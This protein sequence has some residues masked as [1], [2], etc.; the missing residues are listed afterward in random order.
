MPG[1][2][3]KLHK[4]LYIGLHTHTRRRTICAVAL[5]SLSVAMCIAASAPA[6][7]AR[8][9]I[10][11]ETLSSLPPTPPNIGDRPY[12]ERA[13]ATQEAVDTVLPTILAWAGR[14]AR[15]GYRTEGPALTPGGYQLKTSP[16]VQLVLRAGAAD[17]TRLGAAVGFV[18]RQWAVMVSNAD[19]ETALGN[20]RRHVGLVRLER[21]DRPIDADFAQAFFAHAAGVDKGLGLGYTSIGKTLLYLNIRDASGK[22]VGGLN[23]LAFAER[24]KTAADSF[25]RGTL[26]AA[27]PIVVDAWF[28]ENDW[29]KMP[30]GDH[31]A[32]LIGSDLDKAQVKLLQARADALIKDIARRYGWR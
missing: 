9:L 12:N 5:L 3:K 29:A 32:R 11:F 28:V 25:T 10:S 2:M 20:R 13:A 18:F 31:Y 30:N 14:N 1:A 7:E 24:L 17:A 8:W 21:A 22:P 15:P 26:R 6:Q 23:D 4:K 19:G 16:S 27:P